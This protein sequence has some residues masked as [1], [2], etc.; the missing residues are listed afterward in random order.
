MKKDRS[1]ILVTITG[2]F[3][4]VILSVM[5]VRYLDRS[6][7]RIHTPTANQQDAASST[8]DNT[9]QININTATLEE[10]DTLPGI[11]PVIAQRIIDYRQSIGGFTSLSQLSNV[12]GIGTERLS[13]IMEFISLEG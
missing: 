1:W 11:G 4:C 2:L 8:T 7:A 9:V 10:L 6:P 3:A 12:N 5:L 13:K